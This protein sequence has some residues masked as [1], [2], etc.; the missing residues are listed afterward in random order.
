MD[1]LFEQF[2][3]VL[4]LLLIDFEAAIDVLQLSSEHL[5]IVQHC[6]GRQLV[7]L[8]QLS[9]LL[10]QHSIQPFVQLFQLRPQR[11]ILLF[12]LD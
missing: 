12:V 3:V 11:V 9:G 5:L 6:Y 2:L 8:S 7:L 1:V 4:N 10:L